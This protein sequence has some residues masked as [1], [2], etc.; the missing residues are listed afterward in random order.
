MSLLLRCNLFVGVQVVTEAKARELV[1]F[2]EYELDCRTGELRRNGNTLK[3]QPQPAKILSILVSRAGEVVT[4]D[5]LAEQVWGAD[6]YVDFEHGLNF[7]IRKIRRVLEDDAEDPRYLETI[8][9]QKYR[10]I[11]AVIIPAGQAPRVEPPTVEHSR[12]APTRV[13][14]VAAAAALIAV[15]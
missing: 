4:R 9:K 10:F 5:E 13:F 14:F 1:T 8:P 7:A 2:G 15:G 6:T 11:A 3:L 12:L